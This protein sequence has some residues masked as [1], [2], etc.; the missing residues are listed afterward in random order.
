MTRELFDHL[1]KS[2]EQK[3]AAANDDNTNN[4][5]GMHY[6]YRGRRMHHRHMMPPSLLPVDQN[7]D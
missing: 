6:G 4:Y 7:K 2:F 5:H 3:E 1:V